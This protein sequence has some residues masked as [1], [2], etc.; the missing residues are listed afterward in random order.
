M[1]VDLPHL[2]VISHLVEPGR[3]LLIGSLVPY[4]LFKPPVKGK[5]RLIFCRKHMSAY[6]SA[7]AVASFTLFLWCLFKVIRVTHRSSFTLS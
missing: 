6:A 2:A 3:S 1:R 7:G 4:Q 5:E